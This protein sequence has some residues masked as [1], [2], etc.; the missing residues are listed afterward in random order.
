MSESRAAPPHKQAEKAALIASLPPGRDLWVFTY[1][2]LMWNPEFAFVERVPA[3][4]HGYHRAFCVFSHTYRGT[5]ER[6]GLVLGLDRGGSCMGFAYRIAAAARVEAIQALW[7]REMDNGVYDAR[8]LK[9]RSRGK[10]HSALAFTVD[11]LHAHYAGGLSI[12]RTASL[13]RQGVGARG[14]NIDYLASLVEHLDALG[15]KDGE[16]HRLLRLAGRG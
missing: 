6:P 13:V 2:S 12:E 3:R 8:L 7:Q 5:P 14:R 16:M 1:G 11:R 4:V 10:L 9:V 15:I